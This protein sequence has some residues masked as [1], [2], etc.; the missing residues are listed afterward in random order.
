MM[1]KQQVFETRWGHTELQKKVERKLDSRFIRLENVRPIGKDLRKMT[2]TLEKW[3]LEDLNKLKRNKF[4]PVSELIRIFQNKYGEE[5]IRNMR[6]KLEES[7]KN[8]KSKALGQN[9]KLS[10]SN[11][12]IIYDNCMLTVKSLL[13]KYP[14]LTKNT[15]E[16]TIVWYI[17]CV[18]AEL[19][20]VRTGLPP[21]FYEK[22][23]EWY[24]STH[25]QPLC[26][27]GSAGI[28]KSALKHMS[29]AEKEKL[30]YSIED[31]SK[32]LSRTRKTKK[33]IE[34]SEHST[35]NVESSTPVIDTHTPAAS[36]TSDLCQPVLTSTS[37]VSKDVVC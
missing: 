17:D 11:F 14:E 21:H 2:D 9:C 29:Q 19:K 24:S 15:K 33:E 34:D 20:G 23:R 12:K 18:R 30:G 8:N 4:R 7:E 36:E 6:L 35:N 32:V 31:P 37:E 22:L 28:R 3:D 16:S 10:D 13:A 25:P 5:E 27:R 26:A 1:S